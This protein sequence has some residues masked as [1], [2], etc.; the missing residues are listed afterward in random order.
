MI[1]NDNVVELTLRNLKTIKL[2]KLLLPKDRELTREDYETITKIDALI[3]AAREH[4][5]RQQ[6]FL[7]NRRR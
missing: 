1:W 4:E 6:M 5:E 2:W 3:I 7:K